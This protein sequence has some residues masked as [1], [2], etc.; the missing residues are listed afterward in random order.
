MNEIFRR[1]LLNKCAANH[2]TVH[3]NIEVRSK[4]KCFTL[5]IAKETVRLRPNSLQCFSL[6]FEYPA[7]RETYS[8]ACFRF[9]EYED[10]YIL[11]IYLLPK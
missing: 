10:A 7:Y 3:E 8:G 4:T 9:G 5:S 1:T 2:I 6:P 11:S